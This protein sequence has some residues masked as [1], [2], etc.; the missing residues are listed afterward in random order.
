MRCN[1]AE[2]AR[3]SPDPSTKP[4]IKPDVFIKPHIT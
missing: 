4:V 3:E 1:I 2:S